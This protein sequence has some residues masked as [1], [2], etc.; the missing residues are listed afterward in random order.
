MYHVIE[1]TGIL[2]DFFNRYYDAPEGTSV[3]FAPSAENAD[4]KA[5]DLVVTVPDASQIVS[6]FKDCGSIE[7]VADRA[8]E[9]AQKYAGTRLNLSGIL[10]KADAYLKE[11]FPGI[12][13][14][15][16]LGYVRGLL[17]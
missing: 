3:D 7:E 8:Q 6:V 1:K 2:G 11:K 12:T 5:G 13:A 16:M 4:L 9:L 10:S 14:D 15:A 17:G